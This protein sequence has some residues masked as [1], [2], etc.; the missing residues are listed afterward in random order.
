MQQEG[1]RNV[2]SVRRNHLGGMVKQVR[3]QL[4]TTLAFQFS[5]PR[6]SSSSPLFDA[7]VTAATQCHVWGRIPKSDSSTLQERLTTD[8][9]PTMTGSLF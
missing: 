4:L 9:D 6:S 1:V 5:S 7:T 3:S 2:S 8:E